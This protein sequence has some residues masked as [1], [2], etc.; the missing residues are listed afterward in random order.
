MSDTKQHRL[1]RYDG[2][3]RRV[4]AE[5][6]NLAATEAAE[7]NVALCRTAYRIW[8]VTTLAPLRPVP[9]ER[10][11]DDLPPAVAE[12]IAMSVDNNVVRPAD[13]LTLEVSMIL[14]RELAAPIPKRVAELVI[15]RVR[16][17]CADLANDVGEAIA[18]GDHA[19]TADDLPIES[20][21][22]MAALAANACFRVAGAIRVGGPARL[23]CE[24]V[25]LRLLRDLV[26][27]APDMPLGA[28]VQ[29]LAERLPGG[30]P[31]GDPA[32]GD[33]KKAP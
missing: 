17:S 11:P 24:E 22:D 15:E 25:A 31:P 33:A 19:Y 29:R 9:C 4:I 7:L 23:Y 10:L 30:G 1:V 32:P 27:E 26:G 14:A 16:A 2:G 3:E 12:R 18:D 5:P 20:L 21:D 8:P 28:A 13:G 6:V